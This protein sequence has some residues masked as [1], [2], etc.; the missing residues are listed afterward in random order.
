M[1]RKVTLTKSML[2][3]LQKFEQNEFKFI[4]KGDES[5]FEYYDG[6]KRIRLN[7]QDQRQDIVNQTIE[8]K[9]MIILF[10]NGEFLQFLQIKPSG[11]KIN[12]ECYLSNVIKKLE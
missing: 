10:F 11:L 3:I 5:W 9:I 6:I 7:S 1:K 4:L 8:R 12:T 2:Q